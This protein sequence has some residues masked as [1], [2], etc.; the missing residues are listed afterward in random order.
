MLILL[1]SCMFSALA[2]NLNMEIK[3]DKDIFRNSEVHAIVGQ[4][5]IFTAMKIANK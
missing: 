3:Q 1:S 4:L 5:G 2:T